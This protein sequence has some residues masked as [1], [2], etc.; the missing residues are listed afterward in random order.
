MATITN[1]CAWSEPDQDRDGDEYLAH[2]YCGCDDNSEPVG[3]LY[4]AVS[5]DVAICQGMIMAKMYRVEFLN[6][7]MR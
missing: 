2:F 1:V 7:T 5:R 6:E 3:R 4:H